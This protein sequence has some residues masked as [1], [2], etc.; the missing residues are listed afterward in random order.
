MQ[1]DT[2]TGRYLRGE[3]TIH[4]PAIRHK[5]TQFLT[6][7]NARENNLKNV[8]VKIP[9][10]ALTV[11][12]GV[13]GSGKSS[14]IN[15]T[16]APAMRNLLHRTRDPHGKVTA[17]TGFEELDKVVIIDQMPIGK[18]PRSNPA[19]YTGVFTE[20]REV[21]AQTL[22]ARARGYKTGHF[23]FNTKQGRCDACEGDGVKKIQMHF[24]PDVH[25]TCESCG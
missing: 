7:E 19:T 3:K 15:R 10:G 24:L 21:F 25:V 22:E 8:S 11:V 16:L 5:P 14:L 18:T 2:E 1:S 4:I 17:I 20:I 13:S 9:L 12:T 23:S 6:M